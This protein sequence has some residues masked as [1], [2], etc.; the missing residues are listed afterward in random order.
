MIYKRVSIISDGG[1]KTSGDIVK[2]LA[3]GANAVAVGSQLAGCEEAPGKIVK[4]NG[5]KYKQ[6]RGMGSSEAMSK[7]NFDRYYDKKVK[8]IN[9]VSQ[10]V[11]G[12]VPYLGTVKERLFQLIGGIKSGFG[13]V[14]A[15]NI[16]KLHKKAR[17]IKISNSGLRESHPFGV[18]ITKDEPNYK[19]DRI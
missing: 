3:S 4:I 13:Y 15:L 5:K 2:A 16:N 10:G 7:N 19:R 12:A 9:M 14:G 18:I 8:K 6:Y 11:V 17:F 1:A